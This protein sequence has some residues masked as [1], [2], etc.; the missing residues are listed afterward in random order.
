[1]DLKEFYKKGKAVVTM[2]RDGNWQGAVSGFMELAFVIFET[3]STEGRMAP[4]AGL[5]SKFQNYDSMTLEDLVTK[6]DECCT[7]PE[8]LCAGEPVKGPV[9]DILKPLLLAILKKILLGL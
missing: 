6:F 1:M 8:G 9:L 5:A 3:I 4:A 7:E 2:F